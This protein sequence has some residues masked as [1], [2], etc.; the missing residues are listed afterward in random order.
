MPPHPYA[1]ATTRA[2]RHWPGADDADPVGIPR[3]YDAAFDDWTRIG[4]LGQGWRGQLRPATHSGGLDFGT[5]TAEPAV[6]GF[7][8]QYRRSDLDRM[9]D[10]YAALD[11]GRGDE[12]GDMAMITIPGAPWSKS[13]PRFSKSGRAYPAAGEVDAEE[14][15]AGYLRRVITEPFTG[16]VGI[17]CL[18]FRPNRQRI[19]VDNLIK[20]VCDSANGVLWKDDSQCTAVMGIL[21]LDVDRPRTVVMVAQHTSTLMRG[22]DAVYP[23]PVCGV[24]IAMDGQSNL[25]KTCSKECSAKV[26]DLEL[27]AE[28]VPCGVCGTPFKRYT[29][30]QRHCSPAC[31]H[32]STR[33]VPKPKTAKRSHCE[34]CGK[35]LAHRRG[36]KCRD[37]WK[38][39]PD[40]KLE[41]GALDFG[42]LL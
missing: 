11:L 3:L 31:G 28:L 9:L 10:M 41:Q 25:R 21:E 29:A 17:A 23:C 13:R 2:M 1:H 14:R 33:G 32:A 8:D 26:R 4:G 37:C 15:T 27:L 16:N 19:D 40:V 24:M 39:G 18:F 34:V 6:R 35:T 38:A 36:G 42:A 5:M 30:K 20:H 12:E 22:T 7:V